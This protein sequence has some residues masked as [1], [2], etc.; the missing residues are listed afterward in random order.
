MLFAEFAESENIPE[1]IRWDVE[2]Y[3]WETEKTDRNTVDWVQEELI[4]SKLLGVEF[5]D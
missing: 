3:I 1:S 4:Y 5:G 2:L